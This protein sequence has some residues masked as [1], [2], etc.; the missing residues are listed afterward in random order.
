M[1]GRINTGICAACGELPT[2][3][4]HDHCLGELPGVMNACCGHGNDDSAYLQYYNRDIVRGP[5]ALAILFR[6]KASSSV[7]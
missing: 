6:L 2:A 7:S 3:E 5:G 1:N 4:D